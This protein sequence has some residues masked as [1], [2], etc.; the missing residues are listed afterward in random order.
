MSA[1]KLTQEALDTWVN[2][3]IERQ[4][5]FG[6]KAKGERFAYDRLADASEL[7]LDYDVTM[8]SP[9]KF[10]QPQTESIMRFEKGGFFEPVTE[11][12]PFLLLGVHPYDVVAIS[13]MDAIFAADN[14]DKNYMSRRKQ[15]TIIAC[16][17][18]KMSPNLFAG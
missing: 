16:D 8:L 4:L 6:V 5:V 15:A 9:K 2:G 3:L 7:H 17:I 12:K 18:Q 14:Y 10:F 13:Q 1:K 11:D